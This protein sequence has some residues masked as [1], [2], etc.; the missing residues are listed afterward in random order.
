VKKATT[1]ALT[2]GIALGI[3]FVMQNGD[4][5]AARYQPDASVDLRKPVVIVDY[6]PL[7]VAETFVPKP[8]VPAS[9]YM[10]ANSGTGADPDS[11]KLIAL[12]EDYADEDEAT[13]AAPT[14]PREN[15]CNIVAVTAP[16]E[17][18]SVAITV[19]SECRPE[20]PFTVS[21]SSLSFSAETDA[22]GNATVK[23]PALNEDAT[24]FITFS[25]GKSLATTTYAPAASRYNRV[26]FQWAGHAGSY[27]RS[28]N[29]DQTMLDELGTNV[30]TEPRFAQVY[31]FP[32][33]ADLAASLGAI[34]VV[35]HV[36]DQNCGQVLVAE[37]FSIFPAVEDL[38][39]KDIRITLPSCDQIGETLELK[40]VLGEQ[41]LAAR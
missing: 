21:H 18:G 12:V 13:Q 9:V 5:D 4:A 30:G 11:I 10:S 16:D 41:T 19:L 25:D 33:D 23:V 32:A 29:M 35:A 24:F 2:F 40:K 8:E 7:E 36:T 37:S 20:M 6:S 14:I 1:V 27:L 31:S 39:F 22:E 38:R 26:V 34:D 15:D 17:T 28:N 3:G